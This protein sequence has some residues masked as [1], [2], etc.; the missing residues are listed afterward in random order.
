M[1]QSANSDTEKKILRDVFENAIDFLGNRFGHLAIEPERHMQVLARAPARA[2]HALLQRQ[3][4]LGDF[5][6]YG[7]RSE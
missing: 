6:G 3:Q 7:E 5:V 1:V 4:P 2:G